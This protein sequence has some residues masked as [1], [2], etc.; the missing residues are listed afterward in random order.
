MLSLYAF[1]GE[2]LEMK[3][4]YYNT[5]LPMFSMSADLPFWK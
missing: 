1:L 3:M 4:K 5:D 2:L